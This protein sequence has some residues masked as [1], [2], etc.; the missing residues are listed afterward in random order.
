M[1]DTS[2]QIK[3]KRDASEGSSAEGPAYVVTYRS[4]QPLKVT[5]TMATSAKLSCAKCA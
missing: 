5:L 1:N 2:I 4:T 3:I